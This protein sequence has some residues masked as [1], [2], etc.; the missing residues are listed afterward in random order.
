MTFEVEFAQLL[1]ARRGESTTE[2]DETGTCFVKTLSWPF[3]SHP[4]SALYGFSALG[5]FSQQ[6]SFIKT[7]KFSN[8]WV[9]SWLTRPC[10]GV[11]SSALMMFY[12]SL[13]FFCL[14]CGSPIKQAA[15]TSSLH[16]EALGDLRTELSKAPKRPFSRPGSCLPVPPEN[17]PWNG[18]VKPRW[19]KILARAVQIYSTVTCLEILCNRIDLAGLRQ[20]YLL[21]IQRRDSMLENSK[22]VYLT[23][24]L[25]H[26]SVGTKGQPGKSSS[27]QISIKFMHL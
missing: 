8:G 4:H 6:A 9:S 26:N 22:A 16:R 20:D 17:C 10:T 25:R 15:T 12:F 1:W 18:C 27:K 13:G 7:T 11:S 5:L 3:P 2:P 24:S 23:H 21:F 14:Q 19:A